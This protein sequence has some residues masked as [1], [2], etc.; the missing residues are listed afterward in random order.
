[1]CTF[2][3]GTLPAN[4]PLEHLRQGYLLFNKVDPGGVA[5]ILAPG[6]TFGRITQRYCDCGTALGGSSIAARVAE[7]ERKWAEHKIE[8]LRRKGWSQQRIDRWLAQVEADEARRAK[9]RLARAQMNCASGATGCG[10]LSNEWASPTL[11]CWS[12]TTTDRYTTPTRTISRL[13]QS[14]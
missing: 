2:V 12:M 3:L 14:L 7:R 4:A 8:R 11:A 13:R 10:T 1:M 5:S 9:T 6:E